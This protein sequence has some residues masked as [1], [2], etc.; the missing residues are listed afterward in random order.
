MKICMKR[1]LGKVMSFSMALVMALTVIPM[2]PMMAH[3]AQAA[4]NVST[5]T[6]QKVNFNR[7]W[8]FVRQDVENAQEEDYNDS[9]WYNVGLP[10]DF[11]IPYWQEEK[12]YTGYGWYR[13]TFDVK[14][15]WAGK[16]LSLDFEGVFHTAELYINGKFAGSHE[17]GY[18]GFEV[19][20]TDYVRQGS[21]TVAIR[22]NNEWKED[23][24]PRTGEHMFTGGIYRDVN[25][26]VT[27]PVHVTWYGTFVQTPDISSDR[28]NIRMQTE[29]AND[30]GEAQSVNVVNQVFDADKKLITTITSGHQVIAAGAVYNFDNTSD[31]INNPRLWSPDSPYLYTMHTDVQVNGQSVDQYDTTFGFRW[32]EFTSDSGFYLNGEHLWLDGVNA[33]QDHAGWANA[34]TT[35]SLKRDVA[36]IKEAG[37]NFIRGSHYPHSPA[38]A[39]A[40]D[41]QGILFWSE[42]AFW[43]TAAGGEGGANGNSEDYK[44]DSY[45]TTG[46]A[47]TE[48]AFEESCLANVRDMI[49]VNR[50]HPSIIA[51]SMGNEVFFGTNHEKKKALISKMAGYAK[52]L[53]PTRATAMGGTQRQGYDKLENVDVAGYNGDGASM[54][55][56]QDPGVAN[57]VAEYGSHTGNRPDQFRAYY[58]N[59]KVDGSGS[60]EQPEWR[61]GQALWCAFHHGSI[62]ARSYGDMG[63]IDYYRLPLQSWYYYREM[64][65]GVE[66]EC[67]TT[68]TPSKLSLQATDTEITN[69]GTSD[70]QII[71][72]VEDDNGVW[73][74]STPSVTLEVV[75]GPGIFPTGKTMTFEP[76][77]S[78]RD[79][80]AAIEF[81]SY[82]AGE[83]VIRAYSESDPDI[84]PSTITVRT[85]GQG[86][87]D[88]P[89]I[90]TMYGAFMSNGGYVPNS[91]EEP[92]AYRYHNYNGSPMK[93]SSGE[94]SIVNVQDGND[95]TE[96][97]ADAAGS[98]Q[99]FYMELEHGGINLYKAKLQFN[100]KVYPYKI[101]YK[102]MNIDEDEWITLKEYDSST[103]NSR[104]EEESFGGTYMR[105]I[106][107]EFTDVPAGEYANLAELKLYGIRADVEGY[108]TGVRYLADIPWESETA[109]GG[110]ASVDGRGTINVQTDSEL[111]YDLGKE[112]SGYTRFQC[113]A[114]ISEAAAGNP[115]TL[116]IYCDE[117]LI[118]DRKISDPS[119]SESIDISVSRVKKL[120]LAAKCDGGS[121]GVVWADARF[122]GALR[123]ISLSGKNITTQL[124]SGMETLSPGGTL[125][126]QARLSSTDE[127]R[128][129]LAAGVMLYKADGTL[130]GMQAVPVDVPSKGKIVK[131]ITMKLPDNLSVSDNVKFI[132]W[133][134]DTLIPVT[135]TV[136]ITKEADS[137]LTAADF[138]VLQ[139][140]R[141]EAGLLSAVKDAMGIIYSGDAAR[142]T[143]QS[144]A[145]YTEALIN[146]SNVYNDKTVPQAGLDS[147]EAAIRAAIARLALVPAAVP[148]NE[149]KNEPVYTPSVNG[150]SNAIAKNTAVTGPKRG[151][152]YKVG[153][154]RYKV[155]KIKGRTGN[156]T[157]QKM[158]SGNARAVTVP[159]TVKIKGY[160]FK[161]TSIAKKAF[162]NNKKLT[163]VVIGK[164]V[165]S[166]AKKAF[167]KNK[168]LKTVVIKSKKLSKAKAFKKLKKQCF[169]K[170]NKKCTFKR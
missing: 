114:G 118:Y 35:E 5:F 23:L 83:T 19:D 32:A 135:E 160:T 48:R 44:A 81:R 102:K 149:Q 113:T 42:A 98:G 151:S 51:W 20:I 77:D 24:A 11:S 106:R 66:R 150:S 133:D 78:M 129:N 82:Y 63:F 142:Y 79:G 153:K 159:A 138:T 46:N 57:L 67:S 61:S 39:D 4:G 148:G 9:S 157:V 90:D 162:Y 69:D 147:A 146:G 123:D 143:L 75:D 140:G 85:T 97:K 36:M 105:Y 76:G 41:E 93:A 92:T 31:Y 145:G 119:V 163:K 120:K 169:V 101:Q 74:N 73:V 156:V 161:V 116:Q 37:L 21:N 17:G 139:T 16:R 28:S 155:L 84:E 168:K 141:N 164:N 94:A 144:R 128:L 136:T 10:H 45:P 38:Y 86:A 13:K 122:I 127:R 109:T 158:V 7:E 95:S 96:W 117:E 91:V 137:N 70:T 58:G 112:C 27:S 104:P 53:D 3:D 87:S 25:L 22:V 2:M 56:Y 111:V 132:I 110:K 115:V 103:I 65:T 64:N 34:V 60:P 108:K 152:V 12:H 165:T 134:K 14:N 89:S 50:N 49:R 130:T 107:I 80:K 170:N 125:E 88:E 167:Y 54:Q 6:R 68:G 55:E 72:T 15:E 62:M 52:E 40:C 47:E 124:F 30:S 99:W 1:C 126:L 154:L 121:A 166:I 8:K 71:V 43:G 33:H 26:I 29:V 131:N 59:V 100:G 18:T